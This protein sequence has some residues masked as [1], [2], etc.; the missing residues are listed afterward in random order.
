MRL[1]CVLYTFEN[2]TGHTDLRT[3]TT[4]Y[5]DKT[6]HLKRGSDYLNMG[7]FI[8]IGDVELAWLEIK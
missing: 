6:A 8:Y 4:S 5:R 3:D 7:L 1:V 2:N